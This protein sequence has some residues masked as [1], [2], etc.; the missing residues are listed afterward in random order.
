MILVS[1]LVN[2]TVEMGFELH[3]MNGAGE[4]RL[5]LVK[6]KELQSS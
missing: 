3:D 5:V 1:D 6:A 4:M 2:G